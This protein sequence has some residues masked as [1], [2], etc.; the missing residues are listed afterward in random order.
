[1][2]APWPAAFRPCRR[3]SETVGAARRGFRLAWRVPALALLVVATVPVQCLA[4]AASP[5]AAGGWVPRAFHRVFARILGLQVRVIGEPS[6]SARTVFVSNHVSYLDVFAL[7]GLL[8]ARFIAK[9]EMRAWPLLGWLA[10]LQRTLFVSRN[11]QHARGVVS[12]VDAA[13]AEGDALILFAEG[14]TSDGTRVLPFKSSAFAA[15]AGAGV[16]V[17]PVTIVLESVDGRAV[18]TAPAVLRDAYAYYGDMHLG[19]HLWRFLQLQGACVSLRFHRPLA[20]APGS[21]RKALAT[22]A[23]GWVAVGLIDAPA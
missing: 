10:S 11:R 2:R 19:P 12:V 22:E 8:P 3:Q 17:Q 9:G 21:D 7:G 16:E 20:T 18:E 1:M 4:L 6:R 5:R 15:I 14:T 23:N 13:L